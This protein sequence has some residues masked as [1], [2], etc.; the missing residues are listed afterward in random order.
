MA[1]FISYI[2][3]AKNQESIIPVFKMTDLANLY[4]TRL[5]QLDES[6]LPY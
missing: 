3:E 4:V 1:S 2:E 6:I 5:K